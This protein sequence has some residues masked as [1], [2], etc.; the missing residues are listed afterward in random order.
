MNWLRRNVVVLFFG[1][2]LLIQQL[3]VWGEMIGRTPD[4][5]NRGR[6]YIPA[7]LAVALTFLLDG[8][9]GV[10]KLLGS[11][12]NFRVAPKWYAFALLYAPALCV[13][14]VYLLVLLGLKPHVEY[15][16]NYIRDLDL[17]FLKFVVTISVLEE[18]SWVSFGIDRLKNWVSLFVA[19]L[20][21]GAVWGLWYVPLNNAGIQVAGQF[22]NLPMVIN[23]M[24]IGAITCWVYYFT[25]SAFLVALM[26]VVTNFTSLTVPVLPHPG[27]ET[28]YLLFIAIKAVFVVALYATIGPKPLFARTAGAPSG[29]APAAGEPLAMSALPRAVDDG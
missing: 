9:K 3:L 8:G 29:A 4:L 18:I 7:L 11:L 19:G 12:L 21:G 27:Q 17:L 20:I 2:T 16:L 5:V 24:F 23:F 25:K 22:P 6:I 10:K 1:S 26:Q 15:D 28:G 14:P 13:A